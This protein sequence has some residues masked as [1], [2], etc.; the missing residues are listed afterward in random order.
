MQA[1]E[2]VQAV[3]VDLRLQAPLVQ[4]LPY[5]ASSEL[6]DQAPEECL[7]HAVTSAAGPPL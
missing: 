5:C 7:R 1:G 3:C 2:Q 4:P 6:V